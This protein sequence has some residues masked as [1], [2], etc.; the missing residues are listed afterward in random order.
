VQ[1][2][3]LEVL[4]DR[5]A[6]ITLS[7]CDGG[8]YARDAR[9]PFGLQLLLSGLGVEDTAFSEV[10]QRLLVDMTVIRAGL[11]E[12]LIAVLR[13]IGVDLGPPS[14]PE[15]DQA[16]VIS[17]IVDALNKMVPGEGEGNSGAPQTR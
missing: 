1:L 2:A 13:R 7:Q 12:I 11:Q 8:A 14:A 9:S 17:S 6:G 15:I 16:D 10:F 3:G 5:G 4:S